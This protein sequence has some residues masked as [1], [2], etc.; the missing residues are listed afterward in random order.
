M[1]HFFI[2]GR[3]PELSLA[4]LHAVLPSGWKPVAVSHEVLMAEC[5]EFDVQEI[6][7]RLG[8]TVKM[9][10]IISH[11]PSQPPSPRFA[12]E[13]GLISDATVRSPTETSDLRGGKPLE[14]PLRV[15]GGGGS[16]ED[17]LAALSA[18]HLHDRKIFFGLSAYALDEK[19]RLPNVRQLRELGIEVKRALQES[20][21]KVRLVTSREVALSSVIVKK[22]KLLTQGAEIVLF[23]GTPNTNQ[24][25]TSYILRT[26]FIGRTLAVQ[27]FEEASIRDFGRPARSM[28]VGMLPIQLAKILINLARA[29]RT[30]TLLD[31][32]C[33]LG[34]ILTEATLMGYKNLIGSYI[35]PHM[36]DATRRNLEWLRQFPPLKVRPAS[37]AKRGEGGE[38]GLRDA[39]NLP[40][41][42]LT[43]REG[44]VEELSKHLTP[45]SVDAIITEPYMGPTRGIR[46]YELGIMNELTKLYVSAFYEFAKILKSGGKVV[47]IFPAFNNAGQITKT[48]AQVLPQIKKLG[49]TPP[50]LLLQNISTSYLLPTTYSITYSRPDQRVLREIFVFT[51][52]S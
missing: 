20:G 10:K 37:P 24:S 43:L 50:P 16:Y 17:V 38:E 33:G 31:P 5:A 23:Y 51:F 6:M 2:L 21:H 26:N 27:E 47:F 45:R 36:I 9:G 28:R 7:K 4:E 48:S 19:T 49:F 39:H 30:A 44:A 15:R 12:G 8:G 52:Q 40:Q 42:S 35:D 13:A 22:E 18:L 32:F 3:N 1:K 29:P 11:N 46:N 14:P 34:T 41:P 25:S